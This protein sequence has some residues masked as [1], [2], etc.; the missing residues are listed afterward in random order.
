MKKRGKSSSTALFLVLAVLSFI[1]ACNYVSVNT[2]PYLGVPLYPPTNPTNVEILR[3]EPLQPHERLGEISLEPTGNPPVAEMEQK[4]RVAA[5]KMGA[6]AAVLVVDRTMLM[7]ATVTGPWYGRQVSPDFQ[8]VII[9]VA[10]R[11]TN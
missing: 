1:P 10:I 7:G 11:Y 2:K 9:A 5:A 3:T 8:R 4:L 6:N